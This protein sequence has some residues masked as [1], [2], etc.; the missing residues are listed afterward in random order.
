MS[1]VLPDWYVLTQ[2]GNQAQRGIQLLIFI[3][4]HVGHN[5]YHEASRAARV[6]TSHYPILWRST[7]RGHE[8]PSQDETSRNKA[9]SMLIV[10]C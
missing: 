6:H 8:K 4:G 9:N 5:D 7:T 2:L 1:E 3:V 10:N